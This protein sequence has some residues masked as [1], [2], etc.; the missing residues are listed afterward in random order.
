M[1]TNFKISIKNSNF[2]HFG[3]FLFL[4]LLSFILRFNLFAIPLERDE[5]EYAYMGQLILEGI[6]PY[7][8]AFN[9]KFP[10]T[11]FFYSILFELF[12]ESVKVIHIGL[13]FVNLLTVIGICFLV[14]RFYSFVAACFVSVFFIIYTSS[15]NLLGFAFHATHLVLFFFIIG[16]LFFLKG[17]DDRNYYVLFL[18]GVL[19]GLS[20]LMKQQAIFLVVSAFLNSLFFQFRENKR[21][22]FR[23]ILILC[24]GVLFLFSMPV[25]YLY[26]KGT[27][28]DFWFWTFTYASK[29]VSINNIAEGYSFFIKSIFEISKHYEGIWILF[30]LGICLLPFSKIEREK[31][32]HLLTLLVCSFL[33]TVPGFYF[34]NHYYIPFIPFLLIFAYIP[35]DFISERF[36]RKYFWIFLILISMILFRNA[37]FKNKNYYFTNSPEQNLRMI[38][39]ISPFPEAVKIAEFIQAN[40]IITDTISIIGSEPEIFFYSKRK[41]ATGYIYMYPLMEKQKFSLELQKKMFD[42]IDL[43][44]PKLIVLINNEIEYFRL[45]SSQENNRY[46]FERLSKIQSNPIY[47]RVLIFEGYHEG[48]KF[49][50]GENLNNYQSDSLFTIDV[51]KKSD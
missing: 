27:L 29:Y 34:R 42:E 31:K 43:K 39:S 48:N 7:K 2:I 25:G 47:K 26:W 38:Y 19:F 46:F 49:T 11:Y 13:F 6:P 28:A 16:Y 18:A 5:G 22:S 9:M 45:N 24:F 33:T 17:R 15:P 32:I 41:S 10:G 40:S 30:F 8:F 12:G 20:I 21:E 4:I 36:G 44:K 3:F 35:F 51:L 23:T 37:I 14:K 50:T 1:F